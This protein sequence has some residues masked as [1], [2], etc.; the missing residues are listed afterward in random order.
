MKPCPAKPQENELVKSGLGFVFNGGPGFDGLSDTMPIVATLSIGP[1]GIG[2]QWY[3]D[4]GCLRHEGAIAWNRVVEVR[5]FK[6]DM[7][8][9]DLICLSIVSDDGL[10]I[11]IDE[12]DLNWEC[13][14]AAISENLPGAIRWIDWFSDVAFP[15]FATNERVIFAIDQNGGE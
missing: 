11:E 14:T 15:A 6:R 1:D 10:V 7:F 2:Y 12:E 9:Y 5:V 3:S 4:G 13:L 8:T